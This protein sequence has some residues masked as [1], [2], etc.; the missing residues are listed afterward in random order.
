MTQYRSR[1]AVIMASFVKQTVERA[2]K[3]VAQTLLALWAA[4][5]PLDVFNI[6][7]ET[8]LGVALGAGLISVLTSIASRSVGAPDSPSVV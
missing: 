2:L 5:G 6:N 8:S 1:S 7:W 4:A 3:T